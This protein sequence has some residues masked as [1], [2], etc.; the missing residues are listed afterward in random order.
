M[1]AMLVISHGGQSQSQKNIQP[2][3]LWAPASAGKQHCL[4]FPAVLVAS[5]KL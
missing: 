3:L 5:H 2:V 4:V 1:S